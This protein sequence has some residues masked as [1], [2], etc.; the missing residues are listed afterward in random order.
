M[1]DQAKTGYAPVNDLNMYYEIHGEGE[2]LVLV[3]AGL[4]TIESSFGHILSELAKHHRVIAVEL[5]GHGH[6]ADIDDR[7]YSYEQFA[8]DVAAL[9]KYLK[10]DK[11]DFFGYSLGAGT[12]LQV[13]M[14]HPELVRKMVLATVSFDN[15][16]IYPA[17][18][19]ASAYMTPEMLDGTPFQIDYKKAAPKPENWN[20]FVEKNNAFE[21]VPQKWSKEDIKKVK[22][23][24]L[25]ITG[26]S[27]IIMPEHTI[28]LFRLLGGGVPGDMGEMAES[29]LA[30]LPATAHIAL[31]QHPQIVPMVEDFLAAKS[32]K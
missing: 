24:A 16:G 26:D 32:S 12:T 4:S 3:H 8:D 27:D 7:P 1:A 13:A 15:D 17:I 23:P 9:V 31:L 25:L 21:K 19:E 6:T 11:A 18:K 10:I 20:R 2:P 5:Q 14:R 28:E 29:R 30:V 22:A